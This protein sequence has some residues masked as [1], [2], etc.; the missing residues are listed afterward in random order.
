MDTLEL[1][2]PTHWACA[3]INGD[4]SGLDDNDQKCFDRFV[5]WIMKEYGSCWCLDVSNDEGDFRRYHDATDFGVL[6]CDV[7]TFTFDI[8][9]R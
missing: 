8:T 9:K 2:L 4:E 1:K 7:A 5:D 3:L 6:A